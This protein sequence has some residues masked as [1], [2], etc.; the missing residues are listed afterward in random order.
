VATRR[1]S[2]PRVSVITIFYNEER[3]IREAVESVLAQSFADYEL[4]LVDDG[5]SDSS[6]SIA[7]QYAAQR[8]E[9][10]RYLA[11]P[12]HSNRGMSASRNLGLSEARGELIAFLDADDRWRPSKLEEQIELLDRLPEVSAVGGAVNYWSSHSG[13]RDRI[14]P[15][16]HVRHQVIDRVEATLRLYPLGVAD[17][18]SMSDLLFRRPSIEAVGGFEDTFTGAYEDQAFL[19]K[20]YLKG[21]LYFT[22]TVWSDYRLHAQSCMAQ[23]RRA[24][25]Y[26]NSRC[27]FLEWFKCYLAE[28]EPV[29]DSRVRRAIEEALRPYRAKHRIRDAARRLPLAVTIVR[30]AK[31][32]IDRMRTLVSAGPAILMYHRIAKA[33][34]DP[35]GLAVSPDHFVEQMSWL[36]RNRAPLQLAEFAE[37][38][39]RGCLPRNAI[40]VTFDDGYACTVSATQVLE[41]LGIPATIFVSPDLVV[42]GREFWWDELERIVLGHHGDSLSLNGHRINL[43][44]KRADDEVWAPSQPPRTPR[45]VAY[46]NLWSLL[47][48]REPKALQEGITQLRHQAAVPDRPRESHR[49]MTWTE[50][51]RILSEALEIGSHSLTHASLPHLD[52][53]EKARE[54]QGS[55]ER[56]AELSGAE[57]RSFA[58]PYGDFDS[59]SERFAREA[60]YVCA[61]KADGWFVHRRTS[62][63]ALPRIF[64][65]DWESARLARRLG[66]P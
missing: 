41:R 20:F 6:S 33:N 18:P 56:C 50:L 46:R 22:D 34:F 16:G 38:H 54:I 5:S 17:A 57:P 25:R 55:R 48:R 23:V 64:V 35:W 29:A 11:H 31:P 12:N 40:A 58:Y 52:P 28:S 60:G 43:G 32:V 53:D 15:T 42:A 14:V 37:L 24:G 51:S 30:S 9:R 59:E 65:G 36:V 8:P 44:D 7:R 19:A 21:R 66:R 47:Y 2:P 39:R 62:R 27:A 45:Q 1:F 10:I 26:H 61:V 63:F 49:P 13:G 3:F 4:L